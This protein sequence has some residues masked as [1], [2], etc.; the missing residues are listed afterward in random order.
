MVRQ[1]Q[2][3][4]PN[5]RA[6]EVVEILRGR[7]HAHGVGKC[8]RTAGVASVHKWSPWLLCHAVQRASVARCC[9]MHA[10]CVAGTCPVYARCVR[11]T[12][13]AATLTPLRRPWVAGVRWRDCPR[14]VHVLLCVQCTFPGAK[15][16]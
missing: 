13:L 6:D 8:A 12:L 14:L 15:T 4:V 11:I 10:P 9:A 5:G 1:I 16:R 3:T 2:I 7:D